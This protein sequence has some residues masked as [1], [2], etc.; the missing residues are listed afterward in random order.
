MTYARR[1]VD[2][3]LD[4]LFPHV[5]AIALDGPKAV[6]KTTTARERSRTQL[7]LDR[8]GVLAVVEADPAVALIRDK[9]LLVDEWQRVPQV[10]DAVR[11]AVDDDPRGGQFLL[12]GSATPSD[13]AALHSGAGRIGRL[14]MRP[15][16]LP[17]RGACSPT[18]SLRSLLGGS[19]PEVVGSCP[20]GLDDY[21]REITASGFPAIHGLGDRARRFQLDSYLA[22]I[23]ERDFPE[24][25]RPLR[26]PA[27]LQA[28]LRA[29]AAASS[30]TARYEAI[31]DAAATGEG[32]RPARSTSLAYRE[33]LER[34]WLI[35]AVPAW[36]PGTNH[37]SRLQQAPKH[38]L[39]DPALA[40]RLLGLDAG[41]LLDG[42]GDVV[43]PGRDTM[44]GALLES[45]AA[46]SVRVFA[47]AAEAQTAHLR[48]TN[49]DHEVDLVVVR[50][51]G[52]VLG[53]EVKTT[54]AV[55]D[56]DTRHLRWLR[57]RIGD[58]ML[59]AVVLTTGHDAY[60]RPDG[61]AVVP[62]GLLGP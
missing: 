5:P 18:V 43:G 56:D 29:Y 13:D 24:L 25:G 9:P 50:G 15:M 42:R 27:G 16:T 28:W 6:G 46:L 52:R 3:E 8:P 59:D 32:S 58:R 14:R 34:L 12:T 20:L 60:R 35:D 53:I 54:T 61:V 45:L 39:A 47:Q 37:L 17:E 30:T 33:V 1:I 21:A 22:T 2:D 26:R 23:A 57:S 55:D 49:R 7:Q 36:S 48:T 11:R 44:L 4:E 31:A 38:Q 40:A 10:W 41:A 51:D 62:L 19:R